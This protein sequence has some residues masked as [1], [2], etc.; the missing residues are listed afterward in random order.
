MTSPPRTTDSPAFDGVVFAGGGCRCFWQAGFWSVA[1]KVLDLR[2]RVVGSV[3]AG[4]AMACAA[5]AG[6]LDDV[7]ESMKRRTRR[8]RRNFYPGNW[9]RGQ[10]I[11]PHESIY[12]ETIREH[13]ADSALERIHAGPE[14]RVLLSRPPAWL[15]R[16][17]GLAGAFVAYHLDKLGRHRRVH[18]VWGRRLGFRPDVVSVR[19]CGSAD[20]LSELILHSSCT[21]PLLPHYQRGGSAILDGGIVDGAPVELVTEAESILVMV[22]RHVRADRLPHRPGRT[23]V[24]PSEPV[25]VDVWDYTS[26]DRLQQTYDLGRRDGEA[27]AEG[28]LRESSRPARVRSDRARTESPLVPTALEA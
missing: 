23:Y 13:L 24:V 17:G 25:P 15:G 9:R 10:P 28:I 5:T 6:V 11:F 4:S 1:S 7:L 2:P 26:P 18:A 16:T 14:I 8:N 12:A 19:S 27:F 3:S 22:P 21:P 20:E